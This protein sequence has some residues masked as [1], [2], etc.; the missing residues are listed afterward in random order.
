MNKLVAVLGITIILLSSMCAILFY[1][2]NDTQTQNSELENQNSTLEA[3][4]SDYQNQTEQLENRVSELELQNLELKNQTNELEDLLDKV[5]DARYVI[6]TEFNING[7]YFI[8]GVAAVSYVNI[9]VENF[10]TNDVN[11]LKVVINATFGAMYPQSV[12]L[13]TIKSGETQ[14]INTSVTWGFQSGT[15]TFIATLM[16]DEISLHE[17]TT[18]L[19]T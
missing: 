11:D 16:Q 3:Q 14:K 19:I 4:V 13:G 9:T 8:G 2:I 17:C 15:R 18:E 5:S 12:Q 7:I 1:Q 10:G 6:I